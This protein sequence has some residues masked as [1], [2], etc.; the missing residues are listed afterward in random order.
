MKVSLRAK[1]MFALGGCIILVLALAVAAASRALRA[2]E[3]NLGSAYARN[4]TQYNKQRILTPVLRELALAE[5]LADSEITRQWLEHENDPA[6]HEMFFAEAERYRRAF[7]DRS[8]FVASSLSRHYYF[9]DA[10]G[11]N[12]GRARYTMKTTAPDDAWFFNTMRHGRDVNLNVDVNAYLKVA[13]V[14]FNIKVKDGPRDLGLVGTGLDLSTFLREFIM[15]HGAGVTPMIVNDS[16]AIL[17]HP[18]PKRIAYAAINDTQKT[19][20]TLFGLLAGE[21]SRDA[22]RSALALAKK[23]PSSP[24]LFWADLDGHRE[25]FAVSYIPELG[26]H[27]VTAVNLKG[28]RLLDSAAWRGLLAAGIALLF[29]LGVV[30]VLVLNRIVLRPL[31]DLTR[32]ARSM[33]EGDYAVSLPAAG[34]DEI[35]DLTRAF[36]AMAVQVRSH[37]EELES[38]VRRRTAELQDTNETLEAANKTVADSIRY[39]ALIQTAIL[40]DKRMGA[41]LPD[42]YFALWRPR[43][44]VGGDFYLFR[45][46][47][48]GYLVGVVDC[49]GHGVPGALMTMAAHAAF[50][51]SVETLGADD[52]A[53]LLTEMD[54]RVRASVPEAEGG[55]VAAHMDAGLAWFD[56][57]RGHVVFAGARTSLYWSNGE[58]VEEMAGDAASIAGRRAARFTNHTRPLPED[59]AFYFTTDGFLDQAG[60]PKGYGFGD[61]RF[62]ELVQ[63]AAA[64]PLHAQKAVFETELDAWR[65]AAAQRDDI[66]VLAI[67]GAPLRNIDGSYGRL[68]TARDIQRTADI[69]VL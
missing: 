58:T 36:D 35:G 18:D 46:T 17:A 21:N 69:V 65:G 64:Q 44:I 50:T 23:D 60:G 9:S 4:A 55:R 51:A 14:W 37:T 57:E 20:S 56:R 53:A 25:L 5:R 27:V 40:P 32:S 15:D 30:L 41:A 16:G 12:H 43:D 59:G 47:P 31:E 7:S 8:F 61:R 48:A 13:K 19:D 68:S 54:R 33:A 39:A 10:K 34:G 3:V 63:R 45:E 49:A 42:G 62:R 52:P 38:T 2:I 22:A 66:T 26:W 28:A 29:L 11:S 24:H 67:A 1:S 6:T